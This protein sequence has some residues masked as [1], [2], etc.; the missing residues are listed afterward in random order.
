MKRFVVAAV[1]AVALLSSPVR[2]AEVSIKL[3]D[4]AQN[5]VAQLPA[6]LDSCVAGLTLR[7]DGAVCRSVAA[8]L[9]ALGNE[10]KS[11][12]ASAA[13]AAADDAAAKKSAADKAAADA[14][15]PPAS[16]APQ[17]N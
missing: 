2:A 7:G 4:G 13:K 5:A 16:P 10:V 6:L 12:Q 1:A 3:D 11:A 17:P 9:V 14:A 15:V 8:F